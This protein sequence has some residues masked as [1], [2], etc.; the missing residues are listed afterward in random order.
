MSFISVKR[1]IPSTNE[2]PKAI[3]E[4]ILEKTGKNN[5]LGLFSFQSPSIYHVNRI[6][7]IPKRNQPGKWRLITDLSFP[8]GS[9]VNDAID[10]TKCSLSYISVDD[11][12]NRAI[13]IAG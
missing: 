8:E 13:Y 11:E 2:N 4:H 6:S 7:V 9:S 12:A 5:I 1:N 10:P 3:D